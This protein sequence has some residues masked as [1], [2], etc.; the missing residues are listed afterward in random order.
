MI[1]LEFKGE[2]Y[3]ISDD[4]A[5]EAGEIV[6]DIVTLSD[7]AAWG[8]SPKFFKLAK[9]FGALLRF[10][11][12]KVSNQDVHSEMMAQVKGAG[13]GAEE[14]LAAQAVGSLVAI[15]MDGA[16]G[17]DGDEDA[18]PLEKGKALSKPRTKRRSKN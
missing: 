6:E 16:P 10:A 4:Q 1:T 7:I 9:C 12:C 14:L 8:Q 17:D 11:G 15:L 13:D 5:F 2:F 3:K 18:A